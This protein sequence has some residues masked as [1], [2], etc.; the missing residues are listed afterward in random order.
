MYTFGKR[1]CYIARKKNQYYVNFYCGIILWQN[2]A[3]KKFLPSKGE[4]SRIFSQIWK[5]PRIIIIVV[6]ITIFSQFYTHFQ[7]DI[8]FQPE[9]RCCCSCFCYFRCSNID[10]GYVFFPLYQFHIFSPFM[11]SIKFCFPKLFRACNLFCVFYI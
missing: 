11:Y 7:H 1:T 3:I 6:I 8:I 4:N 10:C 5:F 9:L 2:M